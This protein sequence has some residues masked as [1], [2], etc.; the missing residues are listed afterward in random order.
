[1]SDLIQAIK[2]NQD[3]FIY[4]AEYR[5]LT[6]PN[7]ENKTNHL[8]LKLSIKAGDWERVKTI[9]ELPNYQEAFKRLVWCLNHHDRIGHEEHSR[10]L[11]I[12]G[13]D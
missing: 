4:T 10:I 9:V 8:L 11:K 5:A 12:I 6:T 1:M 2:D 3:A 13:E 7:P